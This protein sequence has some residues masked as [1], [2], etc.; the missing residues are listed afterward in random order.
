M[1]LHTCL[2]TP[3]STVL[4]EK[5][6]GSQL[7]QKSPHSMEPEGSLPHSQVPTPVFILRVSESEFVSFGIQHAIV[8]AILSS[9]ARPA[10]IF[11]IIS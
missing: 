6:T 4:L 9:A 1:D 2:P 10:L 11:Y 8:C 5:V 7:V 3:S